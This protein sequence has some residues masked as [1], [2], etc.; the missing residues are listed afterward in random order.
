M[1]LSAIRSLAH[2]L[3]VALGTGGHLIRLTRTA[4]DPFTIDQ[5]TPLSTFEAAA[6]EGRWPTLLRTIDEALSDWPPVILAE[7]ERIRAL[8]GA[9]LFTLNLAGRRC[10]AHDEHGRLVALLIYDQ[11]KHWWRAEKV[12]TM[13]NDQ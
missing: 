8:S 2:D 13:N 10:R 12:L 4:A 7:S 5:A 1:R 3:G 11:K 6:R 9:P